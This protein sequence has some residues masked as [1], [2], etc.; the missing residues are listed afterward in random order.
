LVAGFAAQAVQ[1]VILQD[2]AGGVKA[3]RKLA[4]EEAFSH[5]AEL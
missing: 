1:F 4:L 2:A 5:H 3:L